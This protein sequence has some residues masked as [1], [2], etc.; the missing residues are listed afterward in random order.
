[1]TSQYR[2]RRFSDPTRTFTALEPGEI[3]VNTSNRQLSVGDS[4]S[5]SLG[6]AIP[7][8]GVR[9]FD[10]RAQYA[11]D[12][13]V[14]Y[15]GI[16]YR[17]KL[18]VSPGAFN[19]VQWDAVAGGQLGAF[20]VKAG[21]TMT[22]HLGL[23]ASPGPANAVR[24]DYVDG[25]LAGYATQTFV[26]SALTNYALTSYVNTQD[27]KAVL[28]TG[29]VMTGALTLPAGDPVGIQDAT[30]K[31]YVDAKIVAAPGIPAGMI[32]D[33]GGTAP[34][35]GWLICDGQQISRTTY[36]PLYA[37]IG[38]TWG[39]GDGSTTFTLPDFRTR[40]RRHR[41]NSPDYAYVVGTYQ[42][43]SC[44]GTTMA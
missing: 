35:V 43:P 31:A 23:P 4:A 38:D 25:Q 41:D 34:P 7:L 40:Y 18:T 36:A 2:H 10:T 42:N 13:Y 20:V 37:A 9:I 6:A 16:I 5:G 33:F 24:R 44:R 8:L 19:P 22:G 1:M 32:M 14:V 30:S 28:K 21:D 15:Q 29:S 27:A 12:D 11:T 3:A 17:A 26:N 39:S